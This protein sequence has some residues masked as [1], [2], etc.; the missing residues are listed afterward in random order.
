LK[1]TFFVT[2]S[3]SIE[4]YIESIEQAVIWDLRVKCDV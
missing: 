1:I 2:H 3:F 4:T